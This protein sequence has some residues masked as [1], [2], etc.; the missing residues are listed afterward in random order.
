MVARKRTLVNAGLFDEGLA[1]CDDYGMWVRPVFGGAKIPNRRK[2]GARVFIG[3]PGSLG[4]SRAK[5]AEGYSIVLEK[6]KRTPPRKDAGRDVV[7]S[8]VAEIRTRCLPEASPSVA[9]KP[10]CKRLS[11]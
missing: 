9:S 10:I 2:I 8:R 11:L 6:C 5:M 3:R 1:R 7:E 4:Q